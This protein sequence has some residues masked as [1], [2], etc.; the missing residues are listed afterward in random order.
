MAIQLGVPELSLSAFL[1]GDVVSD[2]GLVE[3][4]GVS[5][6]SAGFL[7]SSVLTVLMGFSTDLFSRELNLAGSLFSGC[8]LSNSFLA[9][10]V[11]DPPG[12][13]APGKPCTETSPSH[14]CVSS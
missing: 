3:G 13:P 14:H 9:A 7:T 8:L 1:M 2:L 11:R 10:A 6:T 5:L 12:A 4:S